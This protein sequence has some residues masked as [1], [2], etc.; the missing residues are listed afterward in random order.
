MDEE[1]KVDLNTAS[2]DVIA[3]LPLVGYKRAQTIIDA[4]PIRNWKELEKLPG[5]DKELVNDLKNAGVRLG[6][7]AA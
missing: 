1:L 5:F 6:R 7:K 3:D 4:R 2:L